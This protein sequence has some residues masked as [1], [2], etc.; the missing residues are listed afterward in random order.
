MKTEKMTTGEAL[1]LM[2][3]CLP[4]IE[5]IRNSKTVTEKAEEEKRPDMMWLMTGENRKE[6]YAFL[7][8]V[9]DKTEEEID[10]QGFIET[11]NDIQTVMG[12]E[13][14]AFFTLLSRMAQTL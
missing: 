11:Y 1:D 10:R 9:L 2:V 8:L 6:M 4:H 5:K 14:F 13:F 12:G 7:S 3:K